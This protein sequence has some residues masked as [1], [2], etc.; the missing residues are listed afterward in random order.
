MGERQFADDIKLGDTVDSLERWEAL[1][2][3]LDW[4]EH[5]SISNGMKFNKGK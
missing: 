2:R 3:D 1:Q 4:L 5:W